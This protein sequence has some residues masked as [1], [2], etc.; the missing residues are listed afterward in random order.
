MK[1]GFFTL[2]CKVNQYETAALKGLFHQEGF[3]IVSPEDEADIYIINSC[4]VTHVG[5][6]KSCQALRRYRRAHPDALIVFTGCFPQAHPD[7]ID[8]FNEADIVTGTNHRLKLPQLIYEYLADYKRRI[9]IHAYDA[10]QSIELLPIEQITEHTRAYVKIEDGCNRYCSYCII[11]TARGHVRSKS[12]PALAEEFAALAKSGYQEIV[13]VGINLSSYGMDL[14]NTVDLADV[15]KMAS[16]F[17]GIKRIRLGSLEPDL[18]TDSVIEKLSNIP[19]LCPQFHLSLQSGCDETLKRMRRRY[20]SAEFYELV[21]KIRNKFQNPSIT[22]DVMV[23]FPGET[24]QDFLQSLYFVEKAAFSKVHIFPFSPRRG[25]PAYNMSYQ[26]SN[27]QKQERA[28]KMETV[29]KLSRDKFLQA[30]I[31]KIEPILFEKQI[32]KRADGYTM[33]YI[34][35]TIHTKQQLSGQ[36]H[37]VQIIDIQH[38]RCIGRLLDVNPQSAEAAA[39]KEMCM[40]QLI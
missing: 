15:V 17:E 4:T 2:G 32:G 16:S 12:L 19:K 3:E 14:S 7:L 31:G 24:D 1:V 18:M 9:E 5:D 23:G 20:T 30:E 33:N 22:T 10:Q 27:R 6:K 35:V 36:I 11:P 34:P 26:L 40:K 21:Q 37:M 29:A 38:N 28:V 13:L 25:T 8:K 39:F